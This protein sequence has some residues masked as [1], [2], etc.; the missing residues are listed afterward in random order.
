MLPSPESLPSPST[1]CGSKVPNSSG[2][3]RRLLADLHSRTTA[4]LA[5]I[6]ERTMDPTRIFTESVTPRRELENSLGRIEL[7]GQDFFAGADAVTSP[8][9]L[10]AGP[11]GPVISH[12]N[13]CR[14]RAASMGLTPSSAASAISQA[15]TFHAMA[16][17]SPAG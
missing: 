16:G 13:R 5:P 8:H 14:Q 9:L 15:K 10:S 2:H 11:D 12:R 3:Q 17:W 4:M 7:R 1:G 6:A